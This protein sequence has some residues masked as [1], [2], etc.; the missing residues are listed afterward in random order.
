M[1][2]RYKNK[3]VKMSAADEP[4]ELD[5]RKF[6]AG[7]FIITGAD[8]GKLQPSLKEFGLHRIRNGVRSVGQIA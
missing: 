5:G 2:F 6:A 7:S 3:D 4:F 1:A 8:R